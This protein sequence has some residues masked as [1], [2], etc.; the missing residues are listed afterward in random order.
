MRAKQASPLQNKM[1]IFHQLEEIPND[2]GP[3]VISVG[4]FDGVHLAHQA[5]LRETVAR[6]RAL[7]AHAVAMTFEPH[8]ARV[9]RPQDAPKLITP[10][11]QKIEFLRHTG[12][13]ALV[14]LPFTR[15]VS[16][17]PAKEFARDIIAN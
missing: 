12:I 9:L 13:D 16:L 2:Y 1:R 4:N 10:T 17:I 7:N 14:L 8:P 15:D 11:S 6:A 5:V 3:T